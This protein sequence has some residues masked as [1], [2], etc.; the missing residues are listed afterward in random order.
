MNRR[1]FIA[2]PAVASVAGRNALSQAGERFRKGICDGII[3]EGV[4]LDEAFRQVKRAGFD[5]FEITMDRRLTMEAAPAELKSVAA[6]AR[7]TGVTIITL[8]VSRPFGKTPLNHPDAA[9]R[10]RGVEVVKRAVDIAHALDSAT[11]LLVPSRVG[12]GSRLICGY[13]DTW[14]R[15]GEELAKAIRHAGQA[16]VV[17]T[18]ENVWNKFLLSPLEMRAFVD[19]FK[20]PYMQVHF[21]IGNVMQFGFPQDWIL[22][23]GPRIKAL[24]LKD[25]QVRTNRFVPLM[26]G[27]VEWKEVMAALVKAGYRGWLSPEYGYRAEDP[28]QIGR[29]SAAVDKI[30]ALAG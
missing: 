18:M 22:T 26:E 17:L 20:S 16:K 12:S 10:A 6:A 9:V 23:L 25:F 1:S 24:H 11:I 19:Q 29:L 2:L 7:D 28:G 5:G 3:P 14:K 13:E 30:Y 21:D 27:D 4:P 8:S 15:T